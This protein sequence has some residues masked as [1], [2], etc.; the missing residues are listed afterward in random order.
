MARVQL[1]SGEDSIPSGGSSHSRSSH[2]N[3][4]GS[5][6]GT[7][8]GD[9]GSGHSRSSHGGVNHGAGVGDVGHD[10]GGS[11]GSQ[12]W[13]SHGGVGGGKNVASGVGGSI[14][15][16][17]AGSD[18][19]GGSGNDGSSS[20]GNNGAVGV[21]LL[22]L[23]NNSLD[24]NNL[25]N[26]SLLSGVGCGE[27]GLGLN[28]LGGIGNLNSLEDGGGG[29]D[30]LEDGGGGEGGSHGGGGHG[31]VGALHT[32]AVDVVS[33]VVDGLDESV[34]IDILVGTGGHSIGVTGL[35]T[36]RRTPSMTE[37]ELA[38]FILGMELVGGGRSGDCKP[39]RDE[40]C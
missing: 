2:S 31:K 11:G 39:L 33:D 30:T 25:G 17:K 16:G 12:D 10:L 35:G 9:G 21:T 4:G 15:V 29:L 19:G 3:S 5:H 26:S 8:V 38:E 37:G 36:G 24:G 7:G 14:G 18:Y 34:G 20:G 6:S 40:L 1:D 23:G 22:P 13:G 32:E 27:S 28:N